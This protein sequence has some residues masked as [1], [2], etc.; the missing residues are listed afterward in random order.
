MIPPILNFA[1]EHP[2]V[3]LKKCN[4]LQNS[5]KFIISLPRIEES[6]TL[7]SPCQ[8]PVHPGYDM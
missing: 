6:K 7:I 4:I 8:F 2:D 5:E 1:P 3:V